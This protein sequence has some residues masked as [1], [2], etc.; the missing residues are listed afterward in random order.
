MLDA[1]LIREP[2]AAK[3]A[4]RALLEPSV[5]CPSIEK[6]PEDRRR[7]PGWH[8]DFEVPK[9]AQALYDRGPHVTL[10]VERGEL[11]AKAR[12][13]VRLGQ[14]KQLEFG[15]SLEFVSDRSVSLR[16]SLLRI[17]RSSSFT[18]QG[19]RVESQL[20]QPLLVSLEGGG[21]TVFEPRFP[22]PFPFGE[23]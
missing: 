12:L 19:G 4:M 22:F 20:V 9:C 5:R 11:V 7:N 18:E 6:R 8:E 17:L 3:F 10:N 14:H 13:M 15:S 2:L 23:L 1:V 16:I 21:W